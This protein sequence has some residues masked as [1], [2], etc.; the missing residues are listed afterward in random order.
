MVERVWGHAGVAAAAHYAALSLAPQ[1]PRVLANVAALLGSLPAPA[2]APAGAGAEAGAT[3]GGAE[4]MRRQVVIE[5]LRAAGVAGAGEHGTAAWLLAQLA[6]SHLAEGDAGLAELAASEAAELLPG[7]RAIDALLRAAQAQPGTWAQAYAA[8]ERGGGGAGRGAGAAEEEAGGEGRVEDEEGADVAGGAFEVDR[9][10]AAQQRAALGGGVVLAETDA[11]ELVA[12]PGPASAGGSAGGG[13]GGESEEEEWDLFVARLE[14]AKEAR[15][16]AAAAARARGA[17]WAPTAGDLVAEAVWA[18]SRNGS[19][20]PSGGECLWRRW[21]AAMGEQEAR[22]GGA[23]AGSGAGARGRGAS[24]GRGARRG[25]SAEGEARAEAEGS[26]RESSEAPAGEEEEGAASEPRAGARRGRRGRRGGGRRAAKFWERWDERA[27]A[28]AYAE[29]RAR[30]LGEVREHLFDN[31]ALPAA[32]RAACDNRTLV[33]RRFG[34]DAGRGVPDVYLEA[35]T[36][37]TLRPREV[38]RL[39]LLGARAVVFD[40]DAEVRA[41]ADDRRRGVVR[42]VDTDQGVRLTEDQFYLRDLDWPPPP[43]A[44]QA[45]LDAVPSIAEE[46]RRLHAAGA[47]TVRNLVETLAAKLPDDFAD[48][49]APRPPRAH[50]ARAP[51]P[52]AGGGQ[53]PERPA[54]ARA[55]AAAAVAA[56]G[57]GVSAA[58]PR[59]GHG[60]DMDDGRSSNL[61]LAARA[62]ARAC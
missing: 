42:Y 4:A 41:R 37:A 17:E 32:E 12:L 11:A 59:R 25:G 15:D 49:S 55:A 44:E 34:G 10:A 56:T 13:A 27:R 2:A 38:A 26:E 8:L 54:T 48:G 5:G 51:E 47:L 23:G 28:K 1:D 50:P 9:R 43:A 20:G 57:A 39:R 30:Q 60:R 53:V 46:A 52:H 29:G 24:R 21:S 31:L 33:L 62:G 6:A 19:N 61:R 16:A 40:N 7:S 35:E 14:R 58:G 22:E 45:R 3:E 18:E 36:R